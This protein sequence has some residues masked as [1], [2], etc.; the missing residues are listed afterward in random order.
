MLDFNPRKKS[1]PVIHLGAEVSWRQRCRC[2]GTENVA[3]GNS[4]APIGIGGEAGHRE[5]HYA[6]LANLPIYGAG[7]P[8]EWMFYSMLA[9]SIVN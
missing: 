9:V 5:N 4:P 3:N 6:P 1:L 8:G 2:R 7:L